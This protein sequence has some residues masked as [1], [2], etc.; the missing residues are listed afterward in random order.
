MESSLYLTGLHQKQRIIFG[1][2]DC[3]VSQPTLTFCGQ[4]WY[5]NQVYCISISITIERNKTIRQSKK[6]F[7]TFFIH[8]QIF[9]LVCNEKENLPMFQ[10]TKSQENIFNR[11]LINLKS[12]QTISY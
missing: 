7:L 1:R 6:M 12:F 8:F 11:W 5:I 10:S 9:F 2:T 4:H 3:S